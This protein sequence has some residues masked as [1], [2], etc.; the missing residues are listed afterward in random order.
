MYACERGH[1]D[2]VKT[3]LTMPNIHDINMKDEVN[4]P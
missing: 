2:I 4:K 1:I 3:L